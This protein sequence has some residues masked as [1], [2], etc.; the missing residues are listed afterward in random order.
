M[1]CLLGLFQFYEKNKYVDFNFLGL[2]KSEETDWD[3]ESFYL[4]EAAMLEAMSD[5]ACIISCVATV[6]ALIVASKAA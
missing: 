6:I 4:E 3:F 1:R 2:V 5:I